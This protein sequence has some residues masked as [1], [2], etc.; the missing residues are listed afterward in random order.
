MTMLYRSTDRRC[1]RGAPMVNLSHSASFH[2]REKTAPSNVGIKHL[3]R[4]LP[5][6]KDAQHLLLDNAAASD[7]LPS[8][9][10][11][12]RIAELAIAAVAALIEERRGPS[13][14]T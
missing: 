9:G 7:M 4:F 14:Q 3:E 8:D 13:A 12:R 2:S 11:I 1:R 6:L 5:R 10:E